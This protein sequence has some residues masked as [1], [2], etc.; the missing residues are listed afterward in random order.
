MGQC[1]FVIQ[2]VLKKRFLAEVLS[3]SLIHITPGLVEWHVPQGGMFLWMRVPLLK[4]TY[5]MIMER[6]L[7]YGVVLVPGRPF[8]PGKQ[9]QPSQYLRASF[10]LAT[11]DEM[12]MV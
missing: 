1:L 4:D 10:S 8:C 7:A 11:M 2:I 12:D 3:L 5:E 9:D 6:G